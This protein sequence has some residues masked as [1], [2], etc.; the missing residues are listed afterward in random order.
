MRK[1]LSIKQQAELFDNVLQQRL[2][3]LLP[4]LMSGRGFPCGL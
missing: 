4:T 2:D 1:V 3:D